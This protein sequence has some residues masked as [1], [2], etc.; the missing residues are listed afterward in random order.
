MFGVLC[1]RSLWSQGFVIIYNI[2]NCEMWHMIQTP[3]V[4]I[5]A[6][7]RID[8]MRFQIN[9]YSNILTSSFYLTLPHKRNNASFAR[10][11]H[12]EA[13]LHST[14][15]KLSISISHRLLLF[16]TL[17]LGAP[18]P[19]RPVAFARLLELFHIASFDKLS[20]ITPKL[21]PSWSRTIL[22]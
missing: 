12:H 20:K 6:S 2:N 14:N 16:F 1:D 18:S 9:K 15:R 22:R 17:S 8:I 7:S 3:W 5:A 19:Q 13:N 21:L 10:I 11:T 4:D